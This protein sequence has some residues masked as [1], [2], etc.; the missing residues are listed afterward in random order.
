MPAA[1]LLGELGVSQPTLSRWVKALGPMVEA[2][3]QTRSR[4]LPMMYAPGSQG[5]LA[6]REFSPRPPMPVVAA[7]W[8]AAAAIQFWARVAEDAM[9]SEWFR[10]TATGNGKTLASRRQLWG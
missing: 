7:V 5:E 8:A 6:E 3:G 10:A 1:A 2:L 9:V 4:M